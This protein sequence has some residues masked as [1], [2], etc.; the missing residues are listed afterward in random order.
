MRTDID[1][2]PIAADSTYLEQVLRNL[3]SNSV[4][5]AGEGARVVI[6]VASADAVVRVRVDDDGPGIPEADRARIFELYERLD[7]SAS[8]PGSG[9]GLFVCRQLIEAMGG[10]I[11]A[12]QADSG[13]ARFT[14]ELPTIA[15]ELMSEPGS[16]MPPQRLVPA[17]EARAGEA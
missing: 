5:Y 11:V 10:T 7:E 13:G 3:V 9:I 2:P 15:P 8:Q 1:V 16:E 17:G 14:I 4:K 12:G 6:D